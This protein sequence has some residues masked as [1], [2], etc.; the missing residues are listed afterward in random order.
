MWSSITLDLALFKV[1]QV[2]YAIVNW[3]STPPYSS[4][5]G[6]VE[7][8]ASCGP[9]VYTGSGVAGE[10]SALKGAG[11]VRFWRDCVRASMASRQGKDI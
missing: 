4:N 6:F 5:K 7:V 11:V 10:E 2:S 3:G 1:P 8:K 9:V